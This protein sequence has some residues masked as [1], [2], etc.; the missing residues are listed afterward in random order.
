MALTHSFKETVQAR[1]QR[2]AAFREALRAESIDAF[3][4]GDVET[5]N[6]VLRDIFLAAS[7]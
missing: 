6:A 2:D 1:V 4:A 7:D 5:G 3:L